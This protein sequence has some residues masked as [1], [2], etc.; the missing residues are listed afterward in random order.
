MAR[1]STLGPKEHGNDAAHALRR[2]VGPQGAEPHSLWEQ[3]DLAHGCH[4]AAGR[5]PSGTMK[6]PAFQG[7]A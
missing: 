6:C 5:A 1:Q 4:G 2:V 3:D 7:G